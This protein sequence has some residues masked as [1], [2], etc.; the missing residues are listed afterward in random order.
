[1][2]IVKAAYEKPYGTGPGYN[3]PSDMEQHR[4]FWTASNG[5]RN[6]LMFMLRESG[7]TYSAIG[8]LA[9]VSQSR[10]VGICHVRWRKIRGHLVNFA[11]DV[12]G[13][14]KIDASEPGDIRD[15]WVGR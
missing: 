5:K 7:L 6:E 15:E 13:R 14:A 8:K 10:V 12:H 11:V 3:P 4:R 1:M 9:G 2:D